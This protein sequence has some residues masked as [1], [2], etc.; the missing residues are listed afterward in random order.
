MNINYNTEEDYFEVPLGTVILM[1]RAIDD[2]RG[3]KQSQSF[4]QLKIELDKAIKD[5]EQDSGRMYCIM[6]VDFL[7]CTRNA[8]ECMLP[9]LV[10]MFEDKGR[11]AEEIVRQ[12]KYAIIDRRRVIIRAA[13]RTVVKAAAEKSPDIEP[14]KEAEPDTHTDKADSVVFFM[15][16]GAV[17]GAIAMTAITKVW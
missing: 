4:V 13:E 5:P 14:V 17:I 12:C 1:Y 16:V 10:N 9:V 6:T 15:I 3:I 11:I 2:I 7:E 8:I